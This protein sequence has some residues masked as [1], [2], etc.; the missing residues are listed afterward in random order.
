GE[1]LII[2]ATVSSQNPITSVRLAYRNP[3]GDY[4]YA[5]LQQTGPSLYRTTIP[6]SDLSAVVDYVIEAVDQAGHRITYPSD[7]RTQPIALAITK[8][9]EPPV[10]IH[11]PIT[12]APAEKPLTITAEVRDPSGVKWVHLRYRSV[13]QHQDYQTLTMTP[14]G[15]KDQYSGV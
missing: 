7:G 12:I 3:Q 11:K 8:D 2:R 14:T 9:N 13:N 10:V 6:S 5:S 1:D 15:K 4:R